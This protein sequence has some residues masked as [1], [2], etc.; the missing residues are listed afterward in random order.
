MKTGVVRNNHS[1]CF[2]CLLLLG[3]LAGL[4]RGALL[5]LV[6]NE[7]CPALVLVPLETSKVRLVQLIVG[8]ERMEVSIIGGNGRH[9]MDHHLG[10]LT[11]FL[12][13][14]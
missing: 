11:F 13:C 12:N 4:L 1:L 5:G 14:L 9:L 3:L 2:V 8:L 7:A 6:N 10:L